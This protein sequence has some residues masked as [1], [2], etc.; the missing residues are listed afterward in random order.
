MH[1]MLHIL[2][3]IE[4]AM[5]QNVYF[6]QKVRKSLFLYFFFQKIINDVHNVGQQMLNN[7]YI[8]K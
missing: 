4:A 6:L 3:V 2:Q 7:I 1:F 5:S 8:Q